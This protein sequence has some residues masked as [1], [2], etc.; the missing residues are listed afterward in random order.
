[1]RI[2][3]DAVVNEYVLNA[4]EVVP[5]SKEP[6]CSRERSVTVALR[7]LMDSGLINHRYNAGNGIDEFRATERLTRQWEREFPAL[8]AIVAPTDTIILTIG[9]KSRTFSDNLTAGNPKRQGRL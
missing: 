5:K 1:M 3:M 8:P 9:K 6:R 7:A 4:L 2:E